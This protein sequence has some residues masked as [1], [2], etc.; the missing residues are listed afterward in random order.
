MLDEIERH[1][2]FFRDWAEQNEQSYKLAPEVFQALIDIGAIHAMVPKSLGGSEF[3]AMDKLRLIEAL[4]EIDASTAWVAMAVGFCTAAAAA[5]LPQSTVEKIFHAQPPPEHSQR[6]AVIAGAGAPTGVAR[7]VPGGFVVTGHWR[8]GSGILHAGWAHCGAVCELN[9]SK[10]QNE[11]GAPV[12][13]MCYIPMDA[14]RLGGNWDVIGLRATGSVDFSVEGVFVPEDFTCPSAAPIHRRGSPIFAHSFTLATYIGHTAWALGTGRRLLDELARFVRAQ[15][16]RTSAIGGNHAFQEKYA[17]CEATLLA[18]RAFAHASWQNTQDRARAGDVLD[19][20]ALTQIRLALV[21][22]TETAADIAAFAYRI[23]GGDTL[24][25]GTLQRLCRD[26]Q[27]GCQH[28][29]SSPP[30]KQACGR[31]LAGLAEGEYWVTNSLVKAPT[32]PR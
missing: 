8:Y 22:A 9:G 25:Q 27:A 20:Q 26:I 19:T 12:T 29:T 4:A 24:R 2:A 21:H 10:L 5:Y 15:A 28:M 13:R 31:V 32:A 30:V 11:H 14:V 3:D 16:Q 18:A 6:P 23:A 1:A 17:H 7:A